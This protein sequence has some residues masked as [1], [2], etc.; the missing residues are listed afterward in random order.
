MR[1]L[2]A[3]RT[4]EEIVLDR[5]RGYTV[6]ALD[7]VA[8]GRHCA[9]GGSPFDFYVTSTLSSQCCPAVGRAQGV[10]LAQALKA[11][12]MFPRDSVS[13]VSLGDGSANN[14]HFLSALNLAEY[15]T[16]HKIKVCGL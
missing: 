4:I 15:S 8:G 3:G 16:F 11:P 6:S 1:Q 2:R 5:A 9:I 12:S 13:F 10:A 7:P 14:A